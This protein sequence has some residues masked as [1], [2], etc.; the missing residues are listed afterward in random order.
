MLSNPVSFTIWNTSLI[1]I[2]L[3][4]KSPK[5][6]QIETQK[7]DFKDKAKPRVESKTAHKPGGG[8]KKVGQRSHLKVKVKMQRQGR[9]LQ[10]LQ[11]KKLKE[12]V[13]L[14]KCG[15][16]KLLWTRLVCHKECHKA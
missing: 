7:L 16:A 13:Y 4:T 15:T 6:L 2:Y 1:D 12:R 9:M 11:D 3:L 14:K 8:D 10:I 5:L